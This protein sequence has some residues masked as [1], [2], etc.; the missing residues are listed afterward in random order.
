VDALVARINTRFGTSTYRPIILKRAHHEPPRVFRFLKAANLCYVSSLHD[1]MNLV[2]KEFV[3]AREDERGVL[4]L[5]ELTGAAQELR[6]ALI[7]NPYDSDGF[8]RAIERAIEMP[9]DEQ[10]ARMRRMRHVVAGHDIFVWASGILDSLEHR[11]I[12]VAS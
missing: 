11:R 5:S 1:G 2:A 7:I 10:R 6:D 9:L 12:A 4:V 8:V 3:A